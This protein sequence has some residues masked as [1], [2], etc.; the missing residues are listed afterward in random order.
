MSSDD[1]GIV[2][3]I[4]IGLHIIEDLQH[5]LCRVI[6]VAAIFLDG[7][8]LYLSVLIGDLI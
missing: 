6:L 3:G 7:M 5:A 4:G 1:H 8:M 2:E